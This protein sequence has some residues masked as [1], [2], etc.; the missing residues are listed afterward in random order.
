[1]VTCMRKMV[2][3]AIVMPL[4]TLIDILLVATTML[5]MRASHQPTVFD[6]YFKSTKNSKDTSAYHRLRA[7]LV[8]FKHHGLFCAEKFAIEG[9]PGRQPHECNRLAQLPAHPYYL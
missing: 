7:K 9:V 1:M 3:T 4:I 2:A 6:C 8:I 5:A